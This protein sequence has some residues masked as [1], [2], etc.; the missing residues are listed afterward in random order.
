MGCFFLGAEK[1][2]KELKQLDHGNV[3]KMV[4]CSDIRNRCGDS[5]VH[6]VLEYMP[7][8]LKHAIKNHPEIK[9]NT[10]EIL[11]QV[12]KGG[13]YIHSKSLAHRDIN[14]KN[15]LIDPT[16]M[17]VK[18]C[19]FGLCCEGRIEKEDFPGKFLD[20]YYRDVLSF[21][22]LMVRL[23]LGGSSSSVFYRGM[24]FDRYGPECFIKTKR[25]GGVLPGSSLEM[26]YGGDEGCFSENG[27]YLFL[28]L[29]AS[30]KTGEC[31]VT[32][33]ALKHPFFA[34]GREKDP[35]PKDPK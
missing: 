15:I 30:R 16:G 5:P 17:S 21:V 31:T 11:H 7:C 1:E 3:V 29:I 25:E 10:R 20:G 32:A 9:E 26:L 12:L 8:D 6:I 23:Y 18:I 14:T 19:D 24:F 2:I 4:A 34:E 22:S 13:A 35:L 33:E 28:K 27:L